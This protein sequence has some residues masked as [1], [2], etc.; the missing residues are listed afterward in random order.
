MFGHELCL[1]LQGLVKLAV[2]QLLLFFLL[3]LLL[4][5]LLLHSALFVLLLQFAVLLLDE[6]NIPKQLVHHLAYIALLVLTSLSPHYLCYLPPDFL[7][8]VSDLLIM[9]VETNDLREV[10]D[11]GIV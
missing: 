3:L 4:L 6:G 7:S 11:R 1:L 9:L 5:F 8:E 10:D 2:L